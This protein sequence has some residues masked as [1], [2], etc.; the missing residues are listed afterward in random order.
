[1]RNKSLIAFSLASFFNDMGSDMIAPVWAIFLTRV[2]GANVALLGLIDGIAIAVVAF[3]KGIAGWWSDIAGKRKPFIASGYL[4]SSMSRLG[5]YI[6]TNAFMVIPF[7]IMDRFGKIRG[8]PRNAMIAEI[9]KKKER[10]RTFGLLRSMDSLGAVTGT[11][12]SLLIVSY[13]GIR[14]IMLLAAIPSIISVA[15]IL[16]LVKERRTE[17]LFKGFSLK[18]SPNLARTLALMSVFTFF[19]F[20]YSF[21]I[22]FS[23]DRGFSTQSTILFYLFLNITYSLSA[24]WVGRLSDRM[25]R[26]RV[27]SLGF[28]VFSVS[29]LLLLANQI[30]PAFIVFGLY[31]AISDTMQKTI[32]SELAPKGRKGGIIGTYEMIVGLTAIPGGFFMGWLYDLNPL[33]PFFLS[34]LVSIATGIMFLQMKS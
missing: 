29:N 15:L 5:Y 16:F 23:K 4:L 9:T 1:M 8:A 28:F 6:S 24:Y 3:A 18:M 2:L 11:L 10:G 19:S 13:I 7:K 30:L 25:N 21:L 27:F 31:L 26:F 34:L 12:I 20:T 32:V 22:V 14:E 17:N 33:N